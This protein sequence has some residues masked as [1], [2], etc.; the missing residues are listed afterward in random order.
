SITI[1]SDVTTT[2]T[3]TNWLAPLPEPPT[4]VLTVTKTISGAGSGPFD[5]TITGPNH[6]STTAQINGGELLTFSVPLGVY[7]ITETSPGVGWTT[8][9]TATTGYSTGSSAVVTLTNIITAPLTAPGTI[10]GNVYRDFDADGVDD[11]ANEIGVAGVIVTAYD[12]DGVAQGTATT[13]ASGN[14]TLNTTGNGPYRLEFTNLPTDYE[15]TMHGAGNGTSTQFISAPASNVNFGVNNPVDY[16]QANPDMITSVYY[17]GD[18]NSTAPTGTLVKFAYNSSGASPTPTMLA[19]KA[20]IGSTWGLAYARSTKTIYAS[21]FLKRHVGLGPNGPG[22]IYAIDIN[23]G[24]P[25]LFANLASLGANVGTVLSNN[26]RGLGEPTSPNNDPT[27]FDQVG[28]VGLGDMDISADERTLYVVNLSDKRLYV[29]N[30]PAGTLANSYAI[31]DPG[32]TGGDWRPFGLK[33]RLGS[34]Y[35]GGVCDAATSQLASD[36]QATVYKF[37]G[38]SFTNVLSF[39]LDYPKGNTSYRP[40]PGTDRAWH[41]WVA[42]MPCSESVLRYPEP[43]LSDIEFDV[44]G[45][46]IL[47]F[48]D[49]FTHQTGNANYPPTGT[50]LIYSESGGDI[51]RAC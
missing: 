46:M 11:G 3:A 16:S 31:P 47:G 28:K 33:Y 6:Y 41:P 40:C 18:T 48:S 17:N 37:D 35:V 10:S 42:T 13:D 29:L 19:T 27:T 26:A 21:A 32:C 30:I 1:Q 8:V 45:S 44:D 43:I 14:Y 5:I 25:T 49:R 12:R 4:T 51:L 22:A 36:L 24:T 34:V 39:A 2:V 20:Q 50:T 15:P 38:T 23:G 7:T 9:Y